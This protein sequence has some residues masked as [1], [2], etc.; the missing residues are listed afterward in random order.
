VSIRAL[1][2]VVGLMLQRHEL[3]HIVMA[4]GNHDPA[5]SVWLREMFAALYEDEPRVTVD[6]SPDPYYAY[7]FGKTAI[8]LHHGHKRSAKR[9][10]EVFAAKFKPLFG[11]TAHAYAHTGHLHQAS[12]YESNLMTVE[13]HRTLAS[14]DAYSARGGWVSGRSASVITYHW[15]HG[16]VGRVT[17]S[18]EMC[19]SN[20][21]SKTTKTTTSM[22]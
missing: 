17:I 5:S 15:E 10:D 1:R 12:M 21:N 4:E 6:Q 22:T 18:P 9:V 2:R 20:C 13:G 8:F 16:E 19:Q 14:P 3:V 11:R 7:E